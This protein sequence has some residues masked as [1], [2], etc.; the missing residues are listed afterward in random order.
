MAASGNGFDAFAF[1]NE[2]SKAMGKAGSTI[3][4]SVTPPPPPPPKPAAS[5]V[6]DWWNEAAKVFGSQARPPEDPGSMQGFIQMMMNAAQIGMATSQQA[7]KADTIFPDFFPNPFQGGTQWK[8]ANP[9]NAWAGAFE[10]GPAKMNRIPSVGLLRFYQ[11]RFV[12]FMERL[13]ALQSVYKDFTQ[14][15]QGPL[16]KASKELQARAAELAMQGKPPRGMDEMY[17]LWLEILE[18][19]YMLLM[20][21]ADFLESLKEVLNQTQLFKKARD[22]FF[23]DLLQFLPIPTNTEMDALYKEMYRLK[24]EV[25][26]LKA[27]AKPGQSEE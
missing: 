23:R 26:D 6:F 21:S 7:R 20:R 14:I 22:E 15:M 9:W 25:A 11:E 1:F 16:D 2:W 17:Q 10:S 18:K 27:A 24:K 3:M 19:Q 12:K 13:G 4:D 5:G 8:D